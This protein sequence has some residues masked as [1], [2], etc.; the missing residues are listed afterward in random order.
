MGP[1]QF[2]LAFFVIHLGPRCRATADYE[3]TGRFWTVWK[4]FYSTQFPN[5]L[6]G[7]RLDRIWPKMLRFEHGTTTVLLQCPSDRS[8]ATSLTHLHRGTECLVIVLS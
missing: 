1:S 6:Q 4:I 8:S 2:F 5:R 7:R 3:Y